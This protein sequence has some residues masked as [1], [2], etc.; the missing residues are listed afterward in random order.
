MVECERPVPGAGP[1]R[2]ARAAARARRRAHG[3]RSR[4]AAGGG[5]RR[6]HDDGGAAQHR[7][8]GRRR[9]GR[10][11]RLRAAPAKLELAKI[12]TYAAATKGLDRQR[13]DRD[14]P[15]GGEA[16]AVGFTDGVKAIADA[17]V[18][19]RALA[20][21]RSFDQLIVQHPEEPS[22]G[23]RRR[24]H[25]GRDRDPP[26]PARHHA[27]RRDHHGRAR[28]APGRD[29]RRAATTSRMSRPAPRSRRSA[30][31]RRAGCR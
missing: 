9:L 14:R 6:R 23:R 18:M 22:L 20:Y 5:G 1:G 7:A 15:A 16:G 26:R 27:G 13:T 17:L 10:R 21:A 30:A 24:S 31:P 11:V 8:A 4:P 28:P 2:H 3:D 19:R 29:H 25:R 12:H